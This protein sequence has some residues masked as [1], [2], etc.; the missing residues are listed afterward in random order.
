MLEPALASWIALA[1]IF[2]LASVF[3]ERTSRYGY[4]IIPII[5]G[6]F[7]FIKWLPAIYI[8]TIFPVVIGLGVI[9]FL[10]EQF[11]VRLGGYGA[12]GSLIWKIMSYMVVLQFAIIFVNGIAIFGGT[13]FMSSS[14]A[15]TTIAKYTITDA[16]QIGTSY[17]ASDGWQQLYVMFTMVWNMWGVTW[18]LLYGVLTLYSSMTTIFGLDPLLA[19]VLSM[20]VYL[21]FIFE[22]FILV[23]RPA[24]QPEI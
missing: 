12:T 23:T 24:K 17:V 18:A 9:T 13:E 14:A 2:L 6:F 8:S 15:N 22:L 5:I 4:V 20:G 7:A 3:S 21:M 16:Q 19:G 10:K 1:I 11:R